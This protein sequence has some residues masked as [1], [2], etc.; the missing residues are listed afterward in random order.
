MASA[1]IQAIVYS[2]NT[3]L[4]R[5]GALGALNSWIAIKKPLYFVLAYGS[6]VGA[7]LF[8]AAPL[9]PYVLGSS[10]EV[11]STYLVW[12]APLVA[13][14]G[15]HYLFGDALMGLGKQALRSIVQFLTAIAAVLS[16]VIFIPIVGPEFALYS[17]LGCSL[18]LALIMAS[19]FLSACRRERRHA[20][21][22]ASLERISVGQSD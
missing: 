17:A 15:L 11:A 14:N 16:N 6:V 21:V 20:T 12:L 4:F 18:T 8:M 2:S 1:P 22:G 19:V 10:Y 5:A 9:I 7:C 13:L 3:K